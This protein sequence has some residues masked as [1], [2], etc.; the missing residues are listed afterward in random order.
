M[1]L[2]L[3]SLASQNRISA[4]TRL[5]ITRAISKLGG[6][7]L[8]AVAPGCSSGSSFTKGKRAGSIMGKPYIQRPVGPSELRSLGKLADA[9]KRAFFDRDPHLARP[10]RRRLLAIALCQGA[11]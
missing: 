4:A 10:Y 6:F 2:S 9:E 7:V 5:P 11:A 1:L 3:K 8:P